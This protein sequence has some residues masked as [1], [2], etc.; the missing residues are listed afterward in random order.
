M[1]GPPFS[2][3]ALLAACLIFIFGGNLMSTTRIA[4]HLTARIATHLPGLKTVLIAY[5]VQSQLDLSRHKEA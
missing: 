4:L 5:S 1:I 2:A 3:I